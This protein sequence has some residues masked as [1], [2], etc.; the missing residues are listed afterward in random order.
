MMLRDDS[1][2]YS[3]TTRSSAPGTINGASFE[4]ELAEFEVSTLISDPDSG[5]FL[6][7][8]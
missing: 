7:E 2:L 3:R 4:L 1:C 8:L 6:F 5:L